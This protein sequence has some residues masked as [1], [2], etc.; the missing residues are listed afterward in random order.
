MY[1]IAPGVPHLCRFGNGWYYAFINTFSFKILFFVF[2]F[3][4]ILLCVFIFELLHSHGFVSFWSFQLPLVC[5]VQVLKRWPCSA[6]ASFLSC[7]ICFY[8]AAFI[9]QRLLFFS[10]NESCNFSMDCLLA[11]LY[12]LEMN[13]PKSNSSLEEVIISIISIISL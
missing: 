3:S 13:W 10:L 9:L 8:S 12:S 4:G 6:L 1:F 2:F 7:L 5:H 11:T